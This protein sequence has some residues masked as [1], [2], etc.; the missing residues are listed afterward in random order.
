MLEGNLFFILKLLPVLAITAFIFAWFGWYIRG[1]MIRPVYSDEDLIAERQKSAELEDRLQHSQVQVDA[2]NLQLTEISASSA[3]AEEVIQLQ[4]TLVLE[5][6]ESA[7][8]KEEISLLLRDLTAARTQLTEANKNSQNKL[9]EYESELSKTRHTLAELQ[10]ANESATQPRIAE[11]E[12]ALAKQ[13]Q[14]TNH[15]VA[16]STRLQ[17]EVEE[18]TSQLNSS[19]ALPVTAISPLDAAADAPAVMPSGTK[20]TEASSLMGRPINKDD[21]KII[22]GIGPKIEQ[23]LFEAGIST[24]KKLSETSTTILKQ[25]LANGGDR[26]SLH[27]PTSWPSQALLAEKGRWKELK[28]LQDQLERGKKVN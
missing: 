15:A 4:Q 13:L 18:L 22:E 21:L 28:S 16:K 3:P 19:T 10:Q 7:N 12:S 26:F 14:A 27:T 11:L 1:L 2:L 17:V 24:W 25:I 5:Q 8:Q 6:Q 9:F 20:M 23:L